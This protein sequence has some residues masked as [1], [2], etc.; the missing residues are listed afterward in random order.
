MLT[1]RRVFCTGQLT[2]LAM[3]ALLAASGASCTINRAILIPRPPPPVPPPPVE[4]P[5]EVP[6][7]GIIQQRVYFGTDRQP[8]ASERAV[9]LDAPT[10]EAGA[11]SL[12][13]AWVTVPL[14]LHRAGFIERPTFRTFDVR[15]WTEDPSRHFVIVDR[16]VVNPTAFW[17]ILK[18]D[19]S[20][21]DSEQL[22]LFVH[23]YNVSFDDAV[24]RSAQLAI[25]LRFEGPVALYSWPSSATTLR[26]LADK[27]HSVSTAPSF[28]AFLRGLATQ[29]GARKIHVIAHSM[30]NNALIHALNTMPQE[31]PA[32]S[33]PFL[34]TLIMAAPDVERRT[35]DG[36]A[37]AVRRA[38]RH[39]T[40]YAANSDRALLLSEGISDD[41]PRVGFATPMFVR[42]WLQSR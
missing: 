8:H 13:W 36:M 31:V 17:P 29:T 4:V 39:I 18:N 5:P 1:V 34:D 22:L 37:D 23:G 26:Y 42:E 41:K 3:V 20:L 28:R 10:P 6:P 32:L 19:V 9:F 7:P 40:L 14:A 30:G 11:L 27:D 33:S 24:Y 25:D 15:D 35:F 38:A 12:G 2:C 21:S 16:Q